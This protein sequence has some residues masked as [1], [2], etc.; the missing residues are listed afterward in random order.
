MLFLWTRSQLPSLC[1]S[2]LQGARWAPGL[3]LDRDHVGVLCWQE[4]LYIIGSVE[5]S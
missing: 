1:S 2:F 5:V 4:V 3:P